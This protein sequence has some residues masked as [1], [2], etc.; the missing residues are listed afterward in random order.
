MCRTA[1]LLTICMSTTSHADLVKSPVEITSIKV[2]QMEGDVLPGESSVVFDMLVNTA[3]SSQW[4][5]GFYMPRSFYRPATAN[6]S[7]T[8][9][10]N[11]NLTMQICD[12]SERCTKLVY[13]VAPRFTDNDLSQGYTTI[14]SPERFFVLA[15]GQTYQIKLM[16]DNF[17]SVRNVSTFPQNLFF[18]ND[19]T[20]SHLTTTIN[21]YSLVNYNQHEIN[22]EIAKHINTNWENSSRVMPQTP[23]VPSPVKTSI[24]PGHFFLTSSTRIHNQFDTDNHIAEWM[25]MHIKNDLALR[26]SVD[27]EPAATSGIIIKKISDPKRINHN[28]EGYVLT[29]SKKNI[30][31]EASHS[32][33][34]Y[35]A[36]Q[37]LRQ[38]WHDQKH[39]NKAKLDNQI[40]VDYP[41]YPYRGML[42]DTARHFF[43]VDQIKS[44]IDLMGANKLN[45]LHIHFADDEGFRIALKAYPKLNQISDSRGL[46]LNMGP[47]MLTQKNLVK[48][49]QTKANIPYA[50]SPYQGTYSATDIASIVSYANAN[51]ITVIPEID[52][53]GHSRA[54]KKGLPEAFLDPSDMSKY[55]SVQGYTDD[56]LPVCSYRSSSE[57]G[58]RFTKTINKIVTDVAELFNAQTTIY[59][60][61]NEISIGG[62]EVSE[63]AWSNDPSCTGRW[64]NKSALEKSQLFFSELAN[65]NL[66]LNFSGW[67]QFV[68][69]DDDTLG[70]NRVNASQA[71]HV[72]VWNNAVAG[73][74]QAVSLAKNG[75]SP[76]LAFSDQTYFDITYTPDVEE[77]GFNWATTFSDTQ[78]ALSS[79][80]SIQSAINQSGSFGQNIVGL[81]GALWSENFPSYE[82]LIYMTVPKIAG[83]AEASWSPATTTVRN[84]QL[85]WQSLATR[86]GCG[87]SGFLAYLNERFGVRY[88]GYP[89]GIQLEA[90]QICKSIQQQ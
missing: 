30:T 47:T 60:I 75:Y 28:P 36:I 25:A 86:L 81:E 45:T 62:D 13:Q 17:G 12:V 32:A 61:K 66:T 29:I 11:S 88:R 15:P 71:G 82:H 51:Q 63:D 10:I 80:S 57:L 2:G 58:Q 79:A 34:T 56:V 69:N 73:I 9:N 90:G 26:V 70:T 20:V 76:V 74:P 14:L 38:L 87:Q 42:L 65:A 8:Q 84:G 5:F 85:N 41:T 49:I 78:S 16:H 35:Y 59:A 43:T 4:Q 55:L 77:P 18:I 31:I 39:S 21:T 27:S 44:L 1:L 68:Q 37:S 53:P 40:I 22:A 50:D 6:Q 7:A 48:S 83:L 54:L 64:Q 46:G 72:W 23:I 19:N 67:Q 33:G 89:N 3:I 52:L 24:S